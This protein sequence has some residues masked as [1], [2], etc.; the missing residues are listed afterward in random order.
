MIKSRFF[1]VLILT[2]YVS[3]LLSKFSSDY[4]NPINWSKIT[5]FFF[6]FSINSVFIALTPI[7]LI[8]PTE[9]LVF[10]KE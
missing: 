1:Q 6:F 10:L 5:G 4:K 3:G 9:R 2:I 8:F 7:T